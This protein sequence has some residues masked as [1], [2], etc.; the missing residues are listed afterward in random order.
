MPRFKAIRDFYDDRYYRAEEV[1]EGGDLFY[2]NPHCEPLDG[3]PE[4]LREAIEKAQADRAKKRSAPGPT[5]QDLQAA[6]ATAGDPL[7]GKLRV[8]I[9][10]EKAEKLLLED[11]LEQKNRVI[12]DLEEEVREL[13][14]ELAGLR[15]SADKASPKKA[16]KKAESE[17]KSDQTPAPAGDSAELL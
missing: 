4:G 3:V 6:F 9:E 14:D 17:Q 2:Y 1:F 13:R 8:A 11:E 12:A 7:V 5:D 16:T 10:R 15:A